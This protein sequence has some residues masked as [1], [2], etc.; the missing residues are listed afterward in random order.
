MGVGP[1]KERSMG[2]YILMRVLLR[3]EAGDENFNM[4]TK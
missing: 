3:S 2:N 1:T 4:P